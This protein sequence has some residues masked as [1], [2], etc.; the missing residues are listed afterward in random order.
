MTQLRKI[1]FRKRK[2]NN[3]VKILSTITKN[4]DD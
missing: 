1:Q 2:Y 3:T 4:R